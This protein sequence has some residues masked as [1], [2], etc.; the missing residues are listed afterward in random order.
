MQSLD[1]TPRTSCRVQ[2][3]KT[4]KPNHPPVK[5]KARG[6]T[7]GRN[8][9]AEFDKENPPNLVEHLTYDEAQELFPHHEVTPS[10]T[11]KEQT[12]KNKDILAEWDKN[13][14]DLDQ[15]N[16]STVNSDDSKD[17]SECRGYHKYYSGPRDNG[18]YVVVEEKETGR[19]TNTANPNVY[20]C[21]S[22]GGTNEISIMRNE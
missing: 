20:D 22:K 11:D 1:Q 7:S 9:V 6:I 4:A 5:S 10:A 15:S 21:L 8:S 17:D 2:A 18:G 19:L 13:F 12:R 3:R 16:D 14:E